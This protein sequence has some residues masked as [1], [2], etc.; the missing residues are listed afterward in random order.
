M[1]KF[2][3][4][5][6]YT[7]KGTNMIGTESQP[8]AAPDYDAL[9]E[10]F[11]SALASISA[12]ALSLRD[13]VLALTRRGFKRNQLVRWAVAAGYSQEHV[14]N[15]INRILRDAGF[16]QRKRGAG[17]KPPAQAI[18]LLQYASQL[19]GA[20]ARTYLLAAYRAGNQTPVVTVPRPAKDLK[21]SHFNPASQIKIL[22]DCFFNDPPPAPE[23][24]IPAYL[25]L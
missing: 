17:R 21:L 20:R 12:N 22:P 3:I 16:R 18:A 13:T 7:Y 14:R 24:Q 19:Y 1:P 2:P 5:G 15:V 11:L 6:K 10:Q 4:P 9:K 8:K 23:N 25:N